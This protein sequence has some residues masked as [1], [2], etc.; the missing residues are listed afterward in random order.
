MIRHYR[1]TEQLGLLQYLRPQNG[2]IVKEMPVP[3]KYR[4]EHIRHGQ[5]DVGVRDVGQL[6]PGI[7][8]VVSVRVEENSQYRLSGVDITGEGIDGPEAHQK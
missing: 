3:L 6:P 4:P 5:A 2:K 8:V 7:G 1:I